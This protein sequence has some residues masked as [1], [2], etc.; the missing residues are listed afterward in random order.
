MR[1]PYERRRRR[2]L[3]GWMLLPMAVL[4]ALFFFVWAQLTTSPPSP[5]G[6]IPPTTPTMPERLTLRDVLPT[7]TPDLSAPPRTITFPGAL[8]TSRIIE[9]VRAGASWETRYLGDSVGH[10]QYTSWLDGPGGNIVLAGHVETA[11][12]EPGP[13]AYLFEAQSGDQVILREGDREATYQVTAIERAAPDDMSYVAQDGVP[14]LTLI[15]CTDWDSEEQIYQGRL[16]V[17]AM[18]VDSAD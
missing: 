2:T 1:S 8:L 18:P 3:S 16:I 14:R 13:F 10:L 11:F 5:A 15:T 12:G 4:I 17:V 6:N 7:P 9:A